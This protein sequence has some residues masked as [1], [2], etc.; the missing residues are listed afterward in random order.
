MPRL[1]RRNR[2]HRAPLNYRQ[3][4]VL[5]TPADDDSLNEEAERMGVT[6]SAVVRLA[7][8][9]WIG[10]ASGQSRSASARTLSGDE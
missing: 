1:D 10:S 2:A 4:T 5:L 6:R 8:R 9:D 3:T 7:L